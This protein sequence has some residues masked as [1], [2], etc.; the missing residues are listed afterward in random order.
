MSCPLTAVGGQNARFEDVIVAE[1][2][3]RITL[4]GFLT[5]QVSV[6]WC[7]LVVTWAKL[8][9]WNQKRHF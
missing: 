1:C 9:D 6:F 4:I 8:T 7:G 2:F 5:L 3:E